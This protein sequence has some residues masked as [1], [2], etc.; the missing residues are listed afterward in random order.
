[1]DDLVLERITAPKPVGAYLHSLPWPDGLAP[2]PSTVTYPANASLP[3]AE[4]LIVTYTTA[5]SHALAD[6][7]TPGHQAEDWNRYTKN[8][9]QFEKH[10]TERSPAKFSRCLASYWVTQIDQTVVI[11]AKSDLHLSTDDATLPIRALFKQMIEDCQPRLVITTGTAGGI[12]SSESLG[13][14]LVTNTSHFDC[15]KTFGKEPFAHSQYVC[16]ASAQLA[17]AEN[18]ADIGSLLDAN[19][20][21][22]DPVATH[23]PRVIGLDALQKG[24]HVLTTDFF[25]FDDSANSYGLRTYDPDA[26]MVEMD[27]AVLGL[28][29]QEDLT[30]PPPWLSIRNASDP[31]MVNEPDQSL[32]QLAKQASDI[33]LKYGYWTTVGSAIC[34]W[35]AVVTFSG[36]QP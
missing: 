27:D 22:L 6:T 15:Q 34:C 7:L 23:E 18:Y 33:Y 1:M 20:A 13:D 32:E 26:G 4:V 3:K 36:V 12:G 28:V 9:A 25:A 35:A 31:Q 24:E 16:A 10:L 14:V 30:N 11:C 19:A 2:R 5:E 29:C 17:V 8:W 21:E